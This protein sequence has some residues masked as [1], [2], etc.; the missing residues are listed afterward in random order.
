MKSKQYM[1]AKRCQKSS[2]EY[3]YQKKKKEYKY[4]RNLKKVQNSFCRNG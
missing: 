3:K 2:L 4:Q 1:A